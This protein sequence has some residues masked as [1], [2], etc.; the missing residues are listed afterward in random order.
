MLKKISIPA[1]VLL[2]ALV[3]CNKNANVP[4]SASAA[5]SPAASPADLEGRWKVD[6]DAAMGDKRDDK[7][8]AAAQL[9]KAFASMFMNVKLAFSGQDQFKLTMMSI[10]IEG[11]YTRDGNKLTLNADKVM[12]KTPE[13]L[14]AMQKDHPNPEM[15]PDDLMKPMSAELS[16]DKKSITLHT[17][18]SNGKAKGED[19]VFKKVEKKV[20]ENLLKTDAEKAL[21]GDWSGTVEPVL[22]SDASEQDKQQAE[23]AKAIAPEL[24]L[25]E[26]YT[27]SLDMFMQVGG[28]WSLEDGKLKLEPTSMGSASPSSSDKSSSDKPLVLDV[29]SDNKTLTMN[30]DKGKMTFTK[31]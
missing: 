10:P 2:I 15:N 26:D 13:E 27:F 25:Y 5:P 3:G 14:K 30:D 17:P 31:S 19:L 28:K 20:V 12:G 18:A 16:A 9:G 22:K 6:M 11:H 7:N 24:S 4:M 8:D 29:S 21:A 1:A 23:M